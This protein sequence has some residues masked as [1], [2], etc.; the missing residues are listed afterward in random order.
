MCAI[1]KNYFDAALPRG[2]EAHIKNRA[3]MLGS[4]III[5]YFLKIHVS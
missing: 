2:D 1:K 3:L 4:F 5:Y